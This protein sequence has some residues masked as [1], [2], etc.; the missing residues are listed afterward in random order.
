[1]HFATTTAALAGIASFAAG[2]AA[3]SCEKPD[4][5]VVIHTGNCP[6]KDTITTH[7]VGANAT[8]ELKDNPVPSESTSFFTVPV[9]FNG[10]I[11]L[12]DNST[13]ADASQVQGISLSTYDTRYSWAYASVDEEDGKTVIA[14][15]K[16]NFATFPKWQ[17][18]G[19]GASI[20][21]SRTGDP[22]YVNYCDS[23]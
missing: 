15:V 6:N 13:Y 17:A 20:S 16:I 8:E 3:Q 23:H 12:T 14:P 5:I 9:P 4:L 10:R 18:T 7:V 1:M 2:V 11:Y 19:S 22:L 21:N